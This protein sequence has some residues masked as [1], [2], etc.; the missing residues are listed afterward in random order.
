MAKLS[1]Y[2]LAAEAARILGVSVNTVRNWATDGKIP[3]HRNPANGYRMFRHKDLA[4]FLADAAKPIVVQNDRSA[5][6]E[7]PVE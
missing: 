7:G 5:G 6:A 4:L 1:E 2:V 3:H